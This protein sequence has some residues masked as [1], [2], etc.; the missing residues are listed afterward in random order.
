MAIALVESVK[1]STSGT[2]TAG[3][4]TGANLLIAVGCGVSA[5]PTISDSKG[6]SWTAIHAVLQDDYAARM[7][8]WYSLGGTV[9]SGHTATVGAATAPACI[10][11]AFSGV[12]T[13]SALDQVD[14]NL[15]Y[16]SDISPFEAGDITPTA[17]NSVL[18]AVHGGFINIS[19]INESYTIEEEI[20]ESAGVTLHIAVAYKIQGAAAQTTPD[21]TMESFG[22]MSGSAFNFLEAGGGGAT[23]RRYTLT[24]LGVG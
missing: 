17:A 14:T 11:L 9:G 24:T 6:N 13:S 3:N 15:G 7:R 8:A 16:G 12:A 22:A 4:T 5:D 21:W 18:I 1:S 23:K 19:S 20:T 10:M 2:T